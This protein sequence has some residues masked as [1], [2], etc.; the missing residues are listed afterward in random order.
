MDRDGYGGLQ[1]RK[2]YP[3]AARPVSQQ[4][5]KRILRLQALMMAV[6]Q[7]NWFVVNFSLTFSYIIFT[8]N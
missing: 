2:I 3:P 6:I 1:L 4:T 8:I 7:Q 5:I